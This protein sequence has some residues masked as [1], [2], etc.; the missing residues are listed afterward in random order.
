[1]TSEYEPI[2]AHITGSDIPLGGHPAP[3]AMTGRRRVARLKTFVLTAAEP[4]RLIAPADEDRTQVWIIGDAT[5]GLL[6]GMTR[7]QIA[8]YADTTFANPPE[9]ALLIP[10]GSAALPCV[11][12]PAHTTEALWAASPAA[13]GATTVKVRVI[14]IS[15][16]EEPAD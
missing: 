13:A 15:E 7:G 11:P 5:S 16:P 3:A 8:Q 2:R 4:A 9:D 1:M 14:M 6:V 10:A 12:I